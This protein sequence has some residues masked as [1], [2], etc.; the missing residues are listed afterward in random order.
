[1]SLLKSWLIV[2]FSSLGFQNEFFPGEID[3]VLVA[4]TLSIASQRL[5]NAGF[6]I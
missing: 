6:M 1:L 4:D 2:T 3:Y 5:A